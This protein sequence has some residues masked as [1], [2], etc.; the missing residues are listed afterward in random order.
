[1]QNNRLE[2][3]KKDIQKYI[4]KNGEILFKNKYIEANEINNFNIKKK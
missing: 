4:D 1:M 2:K 3:L